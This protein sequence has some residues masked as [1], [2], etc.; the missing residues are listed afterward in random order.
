MP[1]IFSVSLLALSLASL[2][3]SFV[4]DP[5]KHPWRQHLKCV[6]LPLHSWSRRRLTSYVAINSQ[7]SLFMRKWICAV[8]KALDL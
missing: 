8:G 4:T 6:G 3:S 2:L 1:C 7:R 5:D